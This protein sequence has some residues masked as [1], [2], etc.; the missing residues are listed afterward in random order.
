MVCVSGL[1]L[2]MWIFLI[3]PALA[4]QFIPDLYDVAA[5]AA[6]SA[7]AGAIMYSLWIGPTRPKKAPDEK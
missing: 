7:L 2:Y 1:L 3:G 5:L 6:L 4:D